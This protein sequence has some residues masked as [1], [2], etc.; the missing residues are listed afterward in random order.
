MSFF[1]G[2]LIHRSRHRRRWFSLSW[3]ASTLLQRC[4]WPAHLL[5]DRWTSSELIVNLG[6]GLC[7]FAGGFLGSSRLPADGYNWSSKLRKG[8]EPGPAEG[9]R[10]DPPPHQCL[11]QHFQV[12]PRGWKRR[13]HQIHNSTHWKI[14][15]QSTSGHGRILNI[16]NIPIQGGQVVYILSRYKHVMK[17]LCLKSHSNYIMISVEKISKLLFFPCKCNEKYTAINIHQVVE[18]RFF[19]QSATKFS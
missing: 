3:W 4:C 9:Q 10:Q 6:L 2:L 7:F 8:M 18:R 15:G 17:L 11:H 5:W 1:P 12:L 14:C 19:T 13:C 16:D